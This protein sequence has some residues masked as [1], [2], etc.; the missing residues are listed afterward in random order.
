MNFTDKVVVVTGASAGIGEALA[1][2]LDKRGAT[3]VLAARRADALK[4]V[5]DKLR[6]RKLTI[7]TDV[8]MQA[9]VKALFEAAMKEFG[10]V[11][12]WVNNAGRGISRG[13]LELT[14][15]DVDEM[16][17]D[18]LKSALY[19]MQAII[20][21][22]RERKQGAL[23]N[24]SS[25]LSRVPVMAPV[26][27]V[28]SASKAALNSLTESLRAELAQAFPE[29]LVS[30]VLPGVVATEFGNNALGGGANS[31]SLPDAQTAEE[32]ARAIADGIRARKEDI[33]TRPEGIEPV[34]R[35]LKKLA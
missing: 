32:V 25:L 2:E 35:Y 16:M 13:V 22:F 28:Y 17:K 30:V 14:D 9:Q 10:R 23:V 15:A 18:N 4:A 26:R 29:I 24:V 5:A 20:P 3:L 12:V 21:H 33:Y 8:T 11:D 34:L 27:S 1:L 31:R 7:P 6:G 19:G